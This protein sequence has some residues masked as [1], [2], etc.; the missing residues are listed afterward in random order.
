M[1]S[2]VYEDIGD[3][4]LIWSLLITTVTVP[5]FRWHNLRLFMG[6]GIDLPLDSL[7]HLEYDIG[8]LIIETLY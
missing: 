5:T 8:E 3:S 4:N 6:G 2:Y 7:I 1:I